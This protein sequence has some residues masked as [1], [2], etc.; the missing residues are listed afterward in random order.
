MCSLFIFIQMLKKSHFLSRSRPISR[1]K[2]K[3][4]CFTSGTRV[5]W[6]VTSALALIGL[7]K[8]KGILNNFYKDWPSDKDEGQSFVGDLM[9]CVTMVLTVCR[10][11]QC[12]F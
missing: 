12:A 3:A 9:V 11:Y 10:I 2:K 8:K 4:L 7:I 1:V 6:T 5:K